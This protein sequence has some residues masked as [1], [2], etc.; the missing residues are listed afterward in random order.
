MPPRTPL[1]GRC[2]RG[3]RTCGSHVTTA[4]TPVPVWGR[5]GPARGPIER[6]GRASDRAWKPCILPG[7][8]VARCGQRLA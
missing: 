1:A 8:P 5:Q 4:A 7:T 3:T 2:Q 6:L